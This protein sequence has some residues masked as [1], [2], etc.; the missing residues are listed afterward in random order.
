MVL[1]TQGAVG[2]LDLAVGGIFVYAEKLRMHVSIY[3]EQ[4]DSFWA[5]KHTL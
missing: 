3:I 4:H 1:F 2:F 5:V